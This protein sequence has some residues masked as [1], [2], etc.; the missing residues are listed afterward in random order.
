MIPIITHRA[1]FESLAEDLTNTDKETWASVS[2]LTGMKVNIQPASANPSELA[3][4]VFDKTHIMFIGTTASGVQEGYRV[5]VSGL[6]DGE[7]NRIFTVSGVEDW[8]KGPVPHYQLTLSEL[9]E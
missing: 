4:G 6:Y 5:T 7:L 8:A 1:D 3:T 9:L 2:G